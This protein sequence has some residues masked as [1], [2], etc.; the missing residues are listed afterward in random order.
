M[1]CLYRMIVVGE[2]YVLDTTYRI[3]VWEDSIFWN[4]GERKIME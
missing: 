3:M 2:L 1:G 4:R